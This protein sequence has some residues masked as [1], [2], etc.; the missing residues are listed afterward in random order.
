MV[1][2]M[3]YLGGKAKRYLDI[4]TSIYFFTCSPLLDFEQEQFL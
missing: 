4:S 3:E 2:K 1:D